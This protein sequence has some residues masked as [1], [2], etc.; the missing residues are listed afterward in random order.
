MQGARV[1]G[2]APRRQL[3]GL[4]DFFSLLGCHCDNTD[5]LIEVVYSH[6]LAEEFHCIGYLLIVLYLFCK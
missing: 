1:Q 6:C 4:L 3:Q 2:P 5:V